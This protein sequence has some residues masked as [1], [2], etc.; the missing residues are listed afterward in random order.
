MPS[1]CP[2]TNGNSISKA[3]F[4]LREVKKLNP[5]EPEQTSPAFVISR[6]VKHANTMYNE[7]PWLYLIGF[8]LDNGQLL[9]LQTS[10]EMYGKLKEGTSGTLVWQGEKIVT[11]P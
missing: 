9:Q 2:C 10:E 5:D 11:F 7:C 1:I 3:L 4:G 6:Q 8:Q